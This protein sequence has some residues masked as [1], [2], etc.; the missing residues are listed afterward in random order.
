M[1]VA[2][3]L[4]DYYPG[5]PRAPLECIQ[6]E[7]DVVFIPQGW[8]HAV[9]NL[10]NSVGVAV[11]F[12]VDRAVGVELEPPPGARKKKGKRKRKKK[13]ARAKCQGGGVSR[14]L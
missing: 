10:Q 5:L 7:G 3:W 6:E 8:A 4:Q 14:P 9:L 11:E 13:R 1:S 2:Q 12:G